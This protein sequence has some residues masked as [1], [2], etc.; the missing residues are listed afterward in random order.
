MNPAK[1]FTN[2]D[3]DAFSI[4]NY[5]IKKGRPRGARHGRTEAQK[6]HFIAH[7]AR[8]RCLKKNFDGIHDRFQ[9][10]SAYRDSQ[11]KIGWTE[12]KCIEMDKS[13]QEDHS[14]CPSS[15]E[16]ERYQKNWYITLNKS[17]RNA[18]MKLRS[19][20]REAL[21]NMHR[22]HRE[23]GEER[24]EPIPL[25]QDTKGGIR[26]LLH[27]VPHGGSGMND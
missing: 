23:S 26:R 10:D 16:F 21:T 6:E 22:L 8:R 20:F 2:G 25:Y 3:L 17:G 14:F 19:D 11:L 24:P 27:P 18:P 13:A 12:E 1:V 7:N 15:E 4:Q 5:V 9:R